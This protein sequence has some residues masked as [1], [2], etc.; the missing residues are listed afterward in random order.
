MTS[1][2]DPKLSNL[3]DW[4]RDAHAMEAQA[5]TMLKA[6]ASRIEHYPELKARIEQHIIE[7]QGQARAIAGCLERHG[8]DTSTF[9]DTGGR[10]MASLQG[11]G[12][13]MASDE[14]VKGALI[15]HAFEALEVASY[16]SLRAAATDVGD[17]QTARVCE[18]ILKEEE[19]M[20]QWLHE[21]IPTLT[22][23]FLARAAGP[24]EAK[25]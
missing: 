4:L 18:E 20:Q 19:A 10:L 17:V 2:R 23:Q 11:M 8:E 9:K 3:I 21:H 12:G 22:T 7:T 14:V 13:M 1:Q 16:L 25:R 15:S 24:G 5:E 6:M